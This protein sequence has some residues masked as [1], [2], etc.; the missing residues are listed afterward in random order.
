MVHIVWNSIQPWRVR[1][2]HSSTDNSR[3]NESLTRVTINL[4]QSFKCVSIHKFPIQFILFSGACRCPE[5]RDMKNGTA[6]PLSVMENLHVIPITFDTSTFTFFYPWRA[7]DDVKMTSC[8][9]FFPSLSRSVAVEMRFDWILMIF[10]V[11]SIPQSSCTHSTSSIFH[12]NLRSPNAS[13]FPSIVWHHPIDKQSWRSCWK[14]EEG[15][16]EKSFSTKSK[17]IAVFNY[18]NRTLGFVQSKLFP[19][20]KSELRQ[21]WRVNLSVAQ[22][23][24]SP[25]SLKYE[26]T[27]G[28]RMTKEESCC[29][30]LVTCQELSPF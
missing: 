11:G 28:K 29:W 27:F 4:R 15:E 22:H 19:V 10:R 25:P 2:R 20:I 30:T 17:L 13:G 3:M 16:T 26:S 12:L 24:S 18:T 8:S 23:F 14:L 1:R 6:K 9:W 21:S 7:L 5:K